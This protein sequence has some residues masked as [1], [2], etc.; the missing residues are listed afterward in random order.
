MNSTDI[1]ANVTKPFVENLTLGET[2]FYIS[3]GI[4]GTVFNAL[5]LWIALTYINTEDKPRQIIVINMTV[6]DLLMCIV[7]MKT[8]PWLSHFNLWLCHPYYVIIWT[9]QMCSCLNLVWLNVD[10]LI[11][12]QFPLHYY[13]IVNRKRLLWITAATWGGLY[14]MNIALVTFLKI[15]RGSCLGVSLN[16]Y[17]YLLSPIFYVVMILT[18][19]SLSALIY[20]IAHNLTHM[21]ERQRSKLFRRL[22]FL[23]SSTLWTFFTCLPYRLLYLFSIF[24]GETCQINNYYKTAT[25]LF[26]R[27]LIVGIMIN[28]VITI[29]TQRIYRLRLMRMFGRLREN[30]STEVLMVSN[31]RASERPPEHTPLRCDM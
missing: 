9:C 2:A 3:C 4:V 15:T 14:A 1:I 29:W 13:Q 31:R 10:K 17:V 16:P 30:S 12:I 20:C 7:Y 19:F 23:F 6:A 8:R 5:V 22:F 25:N 11:Y 28:P 24:C 27:L 18:S 26:F 21:E